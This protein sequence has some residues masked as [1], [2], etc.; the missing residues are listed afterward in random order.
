MSRVEVRIRS[1]VVHGDA[2]PFA[3]DVFSTALCGEIEGRIRAASRRSEM[4]GRFRTDAR[5]CS[6]ATNEASPRD[7]RFEST[8]AARVAGRLLR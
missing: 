4:G 2:R 5:P 3:A 8:T 7:T 6:A 1:L